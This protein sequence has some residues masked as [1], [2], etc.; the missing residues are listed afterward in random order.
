MS[1]ACLVQLSDLHVGEPDLEGDGAVYSRLWTRGAMTGM[2][3][4]DTAPLLVLEETLLPERRG[5]PDDVYVVTTGDL[6]AHGRPLQFD[7]ARWCLGDAPEGAPAPKRMVDP[8]RLGEA[9]WAQRAIPGNHDRWPGH[10][11]TRLPL[12]WPHCALGESWPGYHAVCGAPPYVRDPVPIGGTGWSVRF[13]GVDTERDVDP[14]GPYR[15]LAVGHF[16]SEIDELEGLLPAPERGEVRVLLLHHCREAEGLDHPI[17]DESRARLDRFVAEHRVHV[18]MSGHLHRPLAGLRTV[19]GRRVIYARCG[20]TSQQ[21]PDTLRD[22][23]RE[24][25]S[26]WFPRKRTV[27]SVLTHTLRA[28]PGG[29]AWHVEGWDFNEDLLEFEPSARVGDVR[30]RVENPDDP[31]VNPA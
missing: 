13:L 15:L 24:P 25:F 17:T 26:S 1:Q 6:T 8:P 23:Y 14:T 3:G 2:L 28:G 18:L 21:S 12:F 27:R 9:T 5:R 29:L 16:V 4:H 11:E 22:L 31:V 20:T 10:R 19:G 30:G 7:E